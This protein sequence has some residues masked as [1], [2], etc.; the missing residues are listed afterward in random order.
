[1]RGLDRLDRV[2]F[3]DGLGALEADVSA[4]YGARISVRGRYD[5]AGT[6]TRTEPRWPRLM[7]RL[8]RDSSRAALEGMAELDDVLLSRM[9]APVV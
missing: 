5:N 7:S 1:M 3:T 2:Y 8:E 4:L 9:R 6:I